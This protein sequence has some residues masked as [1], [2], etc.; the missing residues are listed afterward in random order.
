MVVVDKRQFPAPLSPGKE[1]EPIVEEAG[2]AR[3]PVWAAAEN[4]TRT[5]IRSPDRPARSELLLRL[6]YSFPQNIL[7]ITEKKLKKTQFTP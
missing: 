2:W 6:S 3:G 1:L 4:L 7:I 5:G